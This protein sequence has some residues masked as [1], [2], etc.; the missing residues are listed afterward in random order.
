MGNSE[1]E[2]ENEVHL[3]S[4]CGQEIPFGT[5]YYSICRHLEFLCENPETEETEIEIEEAEEITSLCRSCGSVFNKDS[6][7]IILENL[8]VPGQE[9]R[10]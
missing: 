8:P 5:P 3:C 7:E 10:N 2:V 6:L 4:K 1:K 9:P